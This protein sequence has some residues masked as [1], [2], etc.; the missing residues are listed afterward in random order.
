MLKELPA[1]GRE[2]SGFTIPCS[3]ARNHRNPWVQDRSDTD[4]GE[5]DR[6]SM[7]SSLLAPPVTPAAAAPA[8]QRY[9]CGHR[10][11]SE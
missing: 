11:A 9:Q 6:C 8:R 3:Q 1:Q 2:N 7:R 10:Q 5:P 4:C